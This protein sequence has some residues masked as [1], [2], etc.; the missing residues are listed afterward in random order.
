MLSRTLTRFLI[1]TVVSIPIASVG[2][3]NA[4]AQGADLEF[5][6]TN[7]TPR[8]IVDFRVD[9]SSQRNWYLN[10]LTEDVGPGETLEVI[11]E[12]GLTTCTYDT[13]ARWS[14]GAEVIEEQVNMCES[15]SWTYSY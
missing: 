11:I 2:M 3:G 13:Y 12:D 9:P 5:S 4:L 14:D 6:I 7:G 10:I 8:S 15:P 1:G